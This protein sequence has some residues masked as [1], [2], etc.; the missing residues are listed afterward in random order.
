MDY[1]FDWNYVSSGTPYVTISK[2]GISMNAAVIKQLGEPEKIMI[3]FDEKACVIGIRPYHNE[4]NVAT[5]DFKNKIRK[6]WIRIGCKDFVKNLTHIT[7]IDFS[8][9]RKFISSFEEAT[10]TVYFKVEENE[11]NEKGA[12]K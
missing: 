6:N 3:G 10:K 5:Y 7:G 9:A 11:E 1:D 12:V 2:L 4:E 8:K